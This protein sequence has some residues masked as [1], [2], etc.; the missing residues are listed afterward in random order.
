[1]ILN[2]NQNLDVDFEAIIF[3]FQIKIKNILKN[4][5]QKVKIMISR[6]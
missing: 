3:F 1:M 6:F 4:V 2:W 5:S